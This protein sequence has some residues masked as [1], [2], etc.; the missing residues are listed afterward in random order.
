MVGLI[1]VYLTV[2]QAVLAAVEQLTQVLRRQAQPDKAMR[3]VIK[4]PAQMQ[5]VAVA[6][7]PQ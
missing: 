7:Q 6:G 4:L 5:E 1:V 2:R 3:V